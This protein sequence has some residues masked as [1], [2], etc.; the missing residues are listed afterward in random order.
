VSATKPLPP[1]RQ[2]IT[3]IGDHHQLV[4]LTNGYGISGVIVLPG[5]PYYSA[6]VPRIEQDGHIHPVFV[7]HWQ[8]FWGRARTRTFSFKREADLYTE[9][10]LRPLR[11]EE[12]NVWRGGSLRLEDI[13]AADRRWRTKSTRTGQQHETQAEETPETFRPRQD[14][15]P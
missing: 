3:S 9:M 11:F 8:D 1:P 7:A 10:I 2:L 15:G 13:V 4:V 12:I 14:D 6:M 5:H